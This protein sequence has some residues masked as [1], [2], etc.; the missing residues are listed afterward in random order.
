[1]KLNFDW[2]TDI[3][4]KFKSANLAQKNSPDDRPEMLVIGIFAKIFCSKTHY[5][6][7]DAIFNY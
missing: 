3:A 6:S 2:P 4:S 1:M 7:N 5:Y